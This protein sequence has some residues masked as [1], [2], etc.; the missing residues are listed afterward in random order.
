MT[1]PENLNR[2]LE[3]LETLVDALLEERRGLREDLRKIEGRLKK[4]G[5]ESS[6]A[7]PG[8]DFMKNL[9]DLRRKVAETEALN[10]KMAR[11]RNQVKERLGAVLGRLDMIEAKLLEQRSLAV[12]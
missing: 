3:R 7:R 1:A 10:Q 8:E 2:K 12:Q 4:M 6:T 5:E 11:D 9:D